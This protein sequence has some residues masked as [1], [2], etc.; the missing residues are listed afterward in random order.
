M[1][2]LKI[3]IEAVPKETLDEIR[4][5]VE[6]ESAE[7]IKGLPKLV[8]GRLEA[9]T[10]K[11]AGMEKESWGN[12][13]K[14]DNCNG[15]QSTIGTY[16]KEEAN[17]VCESLIGKIGEG[18]TLEDDVEEELRVGFVRDV[19]KSLKS[20]LRD[21]AKHVAAH[22]VE[23]VVAETIVD[24]ITFFTKI[25]DMQDP[26]FGDTP[27]EKLVL[28]RVAKKRA[29]EEVRCSDTPISR[30]GSRSTSSAHLGT[31]MGR[32]SR[33]SRKMVGA[34]YLRPMRTANSRRSSRG[35]TR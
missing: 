11:L 25:E 23:S 1:S 4:R 34:R 17:R 35:R 24:P 32:G 7:F 19:Y 33:R 27:M 12:K 18:F 13:W 31:T 28:E 16:L 5:V 20:Q 29:A 26:K 10:A 6:A 30:C 21:R 9:I 8:Q 14:I 22:M 15:R 3:P 2:D